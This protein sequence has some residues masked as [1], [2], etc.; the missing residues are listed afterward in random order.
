[1]TYDQSSSSGLRQSHALLKCCVLIIVILLILTQTCLRSVRVWFRDVSS[2]ALSSLPPKGLRQV[3]FLKAM[4]APALKSLPQLES[5]A[6]L[7]EAELTYPSHCCAFHTWRR[8][9]RWADSRS[10]RRGKSIHI[11]INK[12]TSVQWIQITSRLVISCWLYW[13][14]LQSNLLPSLFI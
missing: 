8:K 10:Q 3:R 13:H 7:L 11:C 9:Q 5:M 6:E 2:T 1:M 14:V 12:Q 4:S